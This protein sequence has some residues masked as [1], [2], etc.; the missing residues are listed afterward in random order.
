LSDDVSLIACH[1]CGSSSRDEHGR[2]QGERLIDRLHAQRDH[3]A[4]EHVRVETVRC[5]W[6][7]KQSCAVH[8]RA[9]GRASYV[10]AQFDDSVES[11]RGL[12]DYAAM[13][14]QSAD[15]VV[16]FRQWPD[17]VRGHFVCRLPPDTSVTAKE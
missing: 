6:L 4:H 15:G 8:V 12:L 10:L 16:P 5:L 7:C 2:T 17:A 14:G 3:A 13:Y 1:T 9:Q 11:A